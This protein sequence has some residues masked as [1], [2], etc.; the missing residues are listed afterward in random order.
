MNTQDYVMAIS[1]GALIGI[2]SVLLL[3][4]N[5][6]IAGIS[7]ITNGLFTTNRAEAGWRIAFI[8]GLIVG[9]FCYQWFTGESL[10]DRT[11]YPV[12]LTIGAGLLVGFGTRLGSGCTSGHGICGISR[13]SGRSIVATVLF[14]VFG[15]IIATSLAR[16]MS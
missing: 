14:I 1:G 9:G 13:L 3:W 8:V 6:R 7:G 16:M 12:W 11:D 5:G 4:F 15:M 2:S 10:I